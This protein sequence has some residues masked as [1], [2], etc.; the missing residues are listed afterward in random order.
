MDKTREKV[1]GNDLKAR[2]PCWHSFP[3]RDSD[4][5]FADGHSQWL[6]NDHQSPMLF[7]LIIYN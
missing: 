1:N 7:S 6:F 4:D 2:G 5:N 3:S